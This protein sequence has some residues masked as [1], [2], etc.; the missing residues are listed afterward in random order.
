MEMLREWLAGLPG[1][2]PVLTVMAVTA[3]LVWAVHRVVAMRFSAHQENKLP[4]QL[5]VVIMLAIGVIVGILVLP[6]TEQTKT[7]L[8]SLF[9]LL[10][11]AIIAFSSTTLV[12]NAM[13]GLMLRAIRSFHAGDFI[14]A[15]DHFGR[16]SEQ[17]LFHTEIQTANR[18]LTAIP[19]AYLVTHPVTVVRHSGTIIETTLSLGY[20]VS[21]ARAEELLVQATAKAGLEEGFVQILDLADHAVVYR[22]AGFLGETRKLVSAGTVLRRAVLDTLHDAGIEIA[23]PQIMLQRPL[24]SGERL[25]PY[26]STPERPRREQAA[27][28]EIVFDKAEEA[29]RVGALRHELEELGKQIRELEKA[30]DDDE[31]T[32]ADAVARELARA[33]RRV[34]EIEAELAEEPAG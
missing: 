2:I 11:T 14:R 5:S 30:G 29:E 4:Q 20:D 33:R 1:L 22:V 8:L 15:G 18:D 7:Q 28:E 24:S 13:A 34:E 9:G 25:I 10:L 16:V 27:P 12:A 17:G 21:H 23:S 32:D 6:I 31:A 3:V 26:A 19:N